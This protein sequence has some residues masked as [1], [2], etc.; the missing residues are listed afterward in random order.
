MDGPGKTVQFCQLLFW[1]F[2]QLRYWEKNL[3]ERLRHI[4]IYPCFILC[5]TGLCLYGRI[6]YKLFL[7]N[8][9]VAAFLSYNVQIWCF[10]CVFSEPKLPILWIIL[11]VNIYGLRSRMATI[12]GLTD[13]N[14]PETS[15]KKVYISWN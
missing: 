11:I 2:L 14:E 5:I 15:T 10:N 7:A 6:I 9:C 8:L 4:I 13:N 12:L 1:C 3:S